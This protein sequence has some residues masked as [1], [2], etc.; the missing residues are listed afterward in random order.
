MQYKKGMKTSVGDGSMKLTP[1]YYVQK[2][3]VRSTKL[4]D[5]Q[6]PVCS[7]YFCL[8]KK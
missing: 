7:E 2:E 4:R 8:S 6:C 3:V 5:N 1:G